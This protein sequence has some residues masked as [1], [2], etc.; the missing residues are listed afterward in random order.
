MD[1]G[2]C[3]IL[4]IQKM[5]EDTAPPEPD[6]EPQEQYEPIIEAKEKDSFWDDEEI[7]PVG[8]YKDPSDTRPE[9]PYTIHYRQQVGTEDVYLG[10][11]MKDPSISSCDAMVITVTLEGTELDDIDLNVQKG[12]LDLR[13]PR[14]RLTMKLDKP[15]KDNLTQAK[16]RKEEHELKITIPIIPQDTKIV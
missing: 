16:W 13:S 2:G 14:Y 1:F 9:P 10:L 11:N 15:T 5:L 12:F 7:T 6:E 3:D 8:F 4:A